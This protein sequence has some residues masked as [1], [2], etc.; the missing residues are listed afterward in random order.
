LPDVESVHTPDNGPPSCRRAA[1]VQPQVARSSRS[2][3]S[4]RN[5]PPTRANNDY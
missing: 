4:A 2:P 1:R 3:I 5:G